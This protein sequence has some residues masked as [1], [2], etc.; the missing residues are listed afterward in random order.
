MTSSSIHV[1][2]NRIIA[3]FDAE[4]YSIVYLHHVIFIQSS[5]NGRL[6]FHVLAI[7]NSA[8][9]NIGVDVSFHM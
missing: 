7:V 6:G 1:A 2:A 9:I 3:P 5:V 8:A 4:S